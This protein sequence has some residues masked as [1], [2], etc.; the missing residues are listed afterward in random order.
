M[1]SGEKL[2]ALRKSRKIPVTAL[3]REFGCSRQYIHMLEQSPQP[4]SR[5][6]L[7]KY[8]LFFN[9]STDYLIGNEE[10][11]NSI[12]IYT[13]TDGQIKIGSMRIPLSFF[14]EGKQYFALNLKH[15]ELYICEKSDELLF[16]KPGVFKYDDVTFYGYLRQYDDGNTWLISLR[17]NPRTVDLESLTILGYTSY[18]LHPVHPLPQNSSFEKPE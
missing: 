1:F 8:S 5:K 6:M 11:L 12:T 2:R 16:Q 9:V 7:E 3:A 13:L 17:H 10:E 4:P 15:G 18:E 14:D